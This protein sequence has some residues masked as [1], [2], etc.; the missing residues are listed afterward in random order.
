MLYLSFS[1]KMELLAPQMMLTLQEKWG[2]NPLVSPKVIF[3]DAKVEQWF[4]L[5]WVK[6]SGVL[7]NLDVQK[8]ETFLW[9]SLAPGKNTHLLGVDILQHVIQAAFM[10]L[11]LNEKGELV[12]FYK[13]L[14][15]LEFF[16]N[17]DLSASENYLL[18]R[19]SFLS[20]KLAFLFL[21]YEYSRPSNY[22]KDLFGVRDG[23]LDAWKDDKSKPFFST[24]PTEDQIES[25]QRALYGKL[26]HAS[27]N[28]GQSFF[29]KALE[30]ADPGTPNQLTL[31]YLYGQRTKAEKEALWAGKSVFLFGVSG[32]SQFHRCILQDMAQYADLHVYIQN[33]CAEFWED[34]NTSRRYT[35]H[36]QKKDSAAFN[37]KW[38]ENSEGEEAFID[39]NEN[40]LLEL[41][42]KA[43][44]DNIKLWCEAS[45]YD[46]NYEYVSITPTNTLSSLQKSIL[47]RQNSSEIK[48]A[49]DDSLVLVKAPTHFR[50][51][52]YLREQIWKDME[53][54]PSL[55]LDD[56]LVI[57]PD[58]D[59]YRVA[60]ER[61][62]NTSDFYS[63]EHL[64][65]TLADAPESESLVAGAIQI[66]L[67][68]AKK[69]E[70]NRL[71]FF[72]LLRNPVVQAGLGVDG[73]LLSAFETWVSQLNVYR[74]KDSNENTSNPHSFSHGVKRL[75]LNHFMHSRFEWNETAFHPYGN[76]ESANPEHLEKFSKII[77]DLELLISH[78][79]TD[80]AVSILKNLISTWILPNDFPGEKTV[81]EAAL[82]ALDNTKWQHF[83]GR[84]FVSFEELGDILKRALMGTR[85]GSG[86]FLL[87]GIAFIKL[88]NARILPMKN[89]YI[90]GMNAAAFPGKN[91][92]STLDLR[93]P[94]ENRQKRWPGDSDTVDK[95]RFAFLCQIMSAEKKLYLS[96]LGKNLKKDEDLYPSS[97]IEDLRSFLESAILKEPWEELVLS[98]DENR[99]LNEIYS[100]RRL[101]KKFIQ[102][103]SKGLVLK[104]KSRLQDLAPLEVPA[105]IQAS[106][107]MYF[108]RNPFEFQIREILHLPE[109]EETT[110]IELEPIEL[111]RLESSIFNKELLLKDEETDAYIL[112]K[113]ETGALPEGVF[114]EK[115]IQSLKSTVQNQIEKINLVLR[116]V[117]QGEEL[118]CSIE[119]E[120]TAHPV[121]LR[122]R[123]D[124]QGFLKDN[125]LV[126][127]TVY[128]NK[129]S[130]H[131]KLSLY[132]N[133]LIK[134]VQEQEPLTI[135]LL[136]FNEEPNDLDSALFDF[137][138]TLTIDHIEAQQTLALF[139]K[140]AYH[141]RFAYNLPFSVL[142]QKYLGIE[143]FISRI[144]GVPS[145]L[146]ESLLFDVD[147]WGYVGLSDSEVSAVIDSWKVLFSCILEEKK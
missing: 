1:A 131:K 61:A 119:V 73:G 130:A 79:H 123:N 46:F 69:R 140:K 55:R 57:V 141:D 59:E 27:E 115:A 96:Y 101:E 105:E 91:S 84:E 76:I 52:E 145:Y 114:S 51:A 56:I 66:I 31:S 87:S 23:I 50:E 88:Q 125:T 45:A 30:G 120:G 109:E 64:P 5:L 71:L 75:L 89:I 25:W 4:R 65:Y 32:L 16:L 44:R 112:Q 99:E 62:F 126:Y 124:W 8:L 117:S 41:W 9:Q 139:I 134:T 49:N 106:R 128:S 129:I 113:C 137:S 108:L 77:E 39:Q 42:G 121:L 68:M 53:L 136:G 83:A 132:L 138:K 147:D 81:K 6:R 85:P 104:R 144:E 143:S 35:R 103:S 78:S 28:G 95:N 18:S 58:L 97:V 93:T 2:P 19:L 122:G 38:Q 36:F 15:G 12:P 110:Q 111:N 17:Q 107:L 7:A 67:Q 20:S 21:E 26:F 116:S 14:D 22:Y 98:L 92:A 3:A 142:E 80:Q 33:P 127:F 11:V 29:A 94:A 63:P 54:D 102:E 82:K 10:S 37:L 135:M 24:S 133:A 13:T 43:G 146:P 48:W 47:D 90:I 86:Q 100:S 40:R 70:I 34:V 74:N 72:E 60:I 118:S